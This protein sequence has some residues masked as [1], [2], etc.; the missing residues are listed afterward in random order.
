MQ[1]DLGVKDGFGVK[2]GIFED[3]GRANGLLGQK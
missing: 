2:N 1:R 3:N